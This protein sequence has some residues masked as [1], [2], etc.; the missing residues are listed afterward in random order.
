MAYMPDIGFPSFN[1]KSARVDFRPGYSLPEKAP[2]TSTF[3]VHP[4]GPDSHS[5]LG[6]RL[7]LLLCYVWSSASI[8]ELAHRAG[9][10]VSLLT[11]WVWFR[12]KGSLTTE[13]S[14]AKGSMETGAG[15]R[16]VLPQESIGKFLAKKS[17]PFSREMVT[18]GAVPCHWHTC[19]FPDIYSLCTYR[20]AA[21]AVQAHPEL[22]PSFPLG[23]VLMGL[24]LTWSYCCYIF[25]TTMAERTRAGLLK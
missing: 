25:Q 23:P 6:N 22:C 18:A 11:R 4:V 1:F 21:A 10:P 13:N 12:G 24:P 20:G 8:W 15:H 5:V 16:S 2:S 3:S 14:K 19:S 17:Y 7:S 9:C